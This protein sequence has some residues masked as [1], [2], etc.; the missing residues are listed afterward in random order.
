MKRREFIILACATVAG[1]AEQSG[2][3]QQISLKPVSIDAG[4][5]TEY[6]NDG[7]Y[8]RFHDAGFFV[9]R[10][11]PKLF[12]ISS[13]CT[14]RHCS[15][16]AQPDHSFYCKCHGSEFDPSGHVTE[17]PAVRDLPVLPTEIDG[18]GHLMIKSIAAA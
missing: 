4:S 17:G 16:K 18:R 3:N 9:V 5:A 14:H 10:R 1:C 2:S 7:V 12:A 15:L 6:A 11:G 13:I 8:D